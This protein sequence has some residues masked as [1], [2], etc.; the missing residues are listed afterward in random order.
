MYIP[1]ASIKKINNLID[2][3]KSP[4]YI[5]Q[6]KKI[7]RIEFERIKDKLI[8]NF[9]RHKITQEIDAG[10]NAANTSGTLGGYGN[11]FTYIGFEES[12][13]PI[14]PI[15]ESLNGIFIQSTVFDK[16]GGSIVYVNYP[17]ARDIF[18]ITP[19]PWAEGRSWAEGI[20][21]GLAGFGFFLS[22]ESSVSRSGGGIQTK[23]QNKKGKFKNTSYISSLIKEFERDIIKL[24]GLKI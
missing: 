1:K 17:T 22:T 9:E 20:E 4:E 15:R 6:A 11:L 10:S 5:I 16:N 3:R 12:T 19:L 7:V 2:L 24:N 18:N 13:K 14:E 23:Q 21:K 8:N